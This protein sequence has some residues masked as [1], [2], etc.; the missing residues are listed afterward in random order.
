VLREGRICELG[1]KMTDNFNKKI[2]KPDI[3]Q[4]QNH[5]LLADF[6]LVQ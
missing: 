3:A 1:R 5:G 6:N 2:A 4:T